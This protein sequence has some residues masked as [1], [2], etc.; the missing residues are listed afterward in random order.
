MNGLPLVSLLALAA[1]AV[2]AVLAWR[3]LRIRDEL[4]VVE[5][6]ARATQEAIYL[7]DRRGVLIYANPAGV[8]GLQ[9]HPG[10]GVLGRRITDFLPPGLHAAALRALRQ[11]LQ[12][13]SL[14]ATR[15]TLLSGAGA[16]RIFAATLTPVQVRRKR[17]V[18]VLARDVTGTELTERLFS[19]AFDAIDSAACVHTPDG[20]VI[21]CNETFARSLGRRKED[22]V[23][24][25]ALAYGLPADAFG[26]AEAAAGTPLRREVTSPAGRTYG[27]GLYPIT[28]RRGSVVAT[29]S[30]C[31]DITERRQAECRM[32][33]AQRLAAIGHLAAGVAH[34]INNLLGAISVSAEVIRLQPAELGAAAA[35]DILAAVERGSAM[36]QKLYRL[37][38]G[39][40]RPALEPLAVSDAVQGV[41]QL[42]QPQLIS[43]GVAVELAVPGGLRVT[44]DANL[45]HQVLMNLVLNSMQAM[46]GGGRLRLTAAPD[47][48]GAVALAVAD[49]GCGIPAEH[50]ERI[51]TPFFTT[52][53]N[54]NGTGLGLSTSL[55]MVRAM[56]GEI[57]VAS[58]PGAG[59]TFTVVLPGAP[60]DGQGR[61]SA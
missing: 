35:G 1:A 51:F 27:I 10:E 13:Q 16:E 24:E 30:L 61:I 49:T 8:A 34:N 47:R 37:A 22:L 55:S 50:M 6:M 57:R 41:L 19:A 3:L 56:G 48:S 4:Q 11:A 59:T 32:V 23:G 52:K 2:A 12:G 53:E 18:L 39:G 40:E 7:V 20:R 29:I 9:R 44:A 60:P 15:C 28:D 42:V 36:V 17:H 43:Q 21:C 58:T 14:P 54:L 26:T 46:P 31:R 25:S 5:T 45:L 33:H 38:G